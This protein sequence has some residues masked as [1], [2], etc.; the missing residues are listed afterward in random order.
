MRWVIGTSFGSKTGLRRSFVALFHQTVISAA[1][2]A[3]MI[4]R[5]RV[6]DSLKEIGNRYKYYRTKLNRIVVTTA[7]KLRELFVIPALNEPATLSA[8]ILTILRKV[9]RIKT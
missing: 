1:Q 8:E 6:H 9:Q 5:L 2:L 3:R 7:L 4:K